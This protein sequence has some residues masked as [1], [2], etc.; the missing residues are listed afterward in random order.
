MPRTTQQSGQ[1][2][3]DPFV[4]LALPAVPAE[5]RAQV[6]D[7]CAALLLVRW[8]SLRDAQQAT[9]ATFEG[10]PYEPLLPSRLQWQQL[11]DDPARTSER[12]RGLA[13]CLSNIL[14]DPAS[15][16]SRH[17][18]IASG[19]LS[20]LCELDETLVRAVVS[21]INE[22]P[23][24]TAGDR[25][26]VLP[27]FDRVVANYAPNIGEYAT[28]P[29]IAR[30]VAAIADPQPGESVYDPCFGFGNFL[31]AAWQ[32]ASQNQNERYRSGA[33]L[34]VSG[35]ELSD[36][37]FLIGLVRMLLVGVESP[38]LDLAN[39][40]GR[41]SPANNDRDGVDVA[42]VNP[43]IGMK[44][45]RESPIVQQ[46]RVPTT[47]SEG[48]FVQHALAQLK[49]RGRAVI[50]LS[51]GFLFRGG[52]DRELRR[53]LVERGQVE[54]VVGLPAGALA[55]YTT[56]R[57][58][59]L[60]LRKQG[61]NRQ[62]RMV[63]AASSFTHPQ[64][65]GT[66]MISAAMAGQLAEM[67]RSEVPREPNQSLA[68]VIATTPG[69]GSIS[70]S[71]WNVSVEELA[72]IDWDLTPRRREK[73]ALEGLLNNIDA[74]LVGTSSV[75]PLSS[76]VELFAGQSIKS[77][78]LLDAPPEGR[79]IGYVRIRDLDQGKVGR[80]SSWLCPELAEI[81]QRQVLLSG[82]VLVSKSGTIGKASVIR[83]GSTESV[84]GNGLYVLRVHKELMD[85]EFFRAYLA[86]AA[87]QNWLAARSR[88]SVIQHLNRAALDELPVPLLPMTLQLRAAE[89]FK[90]YGTD[91]VEFLLQATGSAESSRAAAW[92]AQ[93]DS[94][95]PKFTRDQGGTPTL[96]K[97]D[98]IADMAGTPSAWLGN[99][100]LDD[101]DERWLSPL[102][103]ALSPLAGASQIPPGLGL[104]SVLQAAERGILET[105]QQASGP[106]PVEAQM[107]AI[108]ER[109]NDW[110]CSAIKDLV[111]TARLELTSGSPPSLVDDEGS[112]EIYL[113]LRNPGVVPLRNVRVDSVPDWG[114]AEIPYLAEGGEFTIRLSAKV[115]REYKDIV[116]QLRWSA[117]SVSA[118]GVRG[119]ISLTIQ[120]ADRP[121]Q[122]LPVEDDLGSSPYV[123]GTPLDPR[124]GHDVF[125]G[126]EDVIAQISRQIGKRGNVVLLEGN[127]RSG[128]TSI[129]K[130]L[131]GHTT[132]AGW[133]AVYSSLQGVD[134]ASG[135]GVP[136]E[137]V[138]RGIA[139]SI[140]KALVTLGIETP[141]P[142]GKTLAV[143]PPAF[144]VI[145]RACRAGIDADAPFE[146]FREYLEQVLATLEP[147]K[148][149]LVVMLD[150][151]D[152][153]QEGIDNGVTSPQVPEN[154]RFLIQSYPNVSAILTGSRRLKRLREEYWSVLY[155]LG[156]TI[157]VTALD[158]A[159]ARRVVIEPVQ[160]RLVYAKEAID[161]VIA[162]TAGQPY[163]VQCLC[164][165]IFD[166]AA[167]TKGR[168]I[169]V[170]AVDD[171]AKALVRNNEHFAVL[172]DYAGRG[173]ETGRHRRQLILFICAQAFR[174]DTH[175]SFGPL[176]ELLEQTGVDAAE[177]ALDDDLAHLREL[178][179]ID[180]RGPIGDTEYRLT[181]PLMADW[182]EQQQDRDVVASRARIEAEQENV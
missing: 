181:V 128:K 147:L 88:G 92:L 11:V 153:L 110:L 44:V 168:F 180:V 104:V 165:Q 112:V 30:L 47:D 154:I 102:V 4:E 169:T 66:P 109:L 139:I 159:N 101:R 152:K 161:R 55:P 5:S 177:A 171:S 182:I 125:Y 151:F 9:V 61:G 127:R 134:G 2:K 114:S 17:L 82:D 94:E 79:A 100:S 62:V 7:A 39:S 95:V 155:G 57:S 90:T 163:L 122:P 76:L 116:F 141:L 115:R 35:I 16:L 27:L 19:V 167:R 105:L 60:V 124:N 172:W 86:S 144:G 145:S 136:T 23:L 28:P 85:A 78:D 178:E 97:L 157:Q 150:E 118:E 176:R 160:G 64:G 10:R 50:L 8:A 175:V 132:V 142:D 111:D 48:L 137:A 58:Y 99:N 56:I 63:D 89:Q 174:D 6:K 32:Q 107:R 3:P 49:P 83:T 91:V 59:L 121:L 164:N 140:A 52:L 40:L 133:L 14:S 166:Y 81:Q 69:S 87:C 93:L 67:I 173:P 74:A 70:R 117:T 98:R 71:V 120:M 20:R 72:A 129:L 156:T 73:G 158:E 18:Q 53:Q 26:A 42:L 135:L 15:P 38:R 31:I 149:G 108:G 29:H 162:V 25:R 22:L 138:F 41:A 12:V 37:A 54:A 13:N 126:R 77:A 119:E 51:E 146:C 143:G 43:P 96:S 179:L 148:L 113:N 103:R 65:R 21:L 24:A 170:G 68:N 131:E 75:V 33:L 1:N 80:V 106:S 84:A 46:Y 36:S 34:N 130:H 45:E 123:T